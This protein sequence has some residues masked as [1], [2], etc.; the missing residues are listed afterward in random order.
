MAKFLHRLVLEPRGIVVRF[1]LNKQEI[2]E[3]TVAADL[4]IL[5]YLREKRGLVGTKEGC[6]S[7]DCGACTVLLGD[8]HGDQVVYHSVN[9]CITP[10]GSVAGK[11][12]VTVEHLCQGNLHPIQQAMVEYH[13]SQCGF[14]TPGF[15]M[16]LAGLYQNKAGSVD[17]AEVKECISGNLCRCTGYRP[18]VDAGVAMLAQV[19]NDHDKRGRQTLA[20]PD[21]LKLMRN[22]PQSAQDANQSV[23]YWKPRSMETLNGLIGKHPGAKLI[24]GGTDLGL[25]ITQRYQSLSTLIDVSDVSELNIL[26]CD[27]ETLTI[28]AAVTYATLQTNLAHTFPA[29]CQLLKRLGSQQIRNRGTIGGN[30]ANASPIADIPPVLLSMNATLE[31]ASINGQHRRIKPDDFYLAYKKTVLKENEYLTA[32]RIPLASLKH[33]HRFYKVSKRIE[34]DISSVMAAVRFVIDGGII[35]EAYLAFGG[36]AATPIRVRDVENQ[37]SGIA[38]NQESALCTALQ[39]LRQTLRPLSD[40]R[41]SADYRRQIA[42]NLVEKAWREARGESIPDLSRTGSVAYA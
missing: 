22:N 5:R 38:L 33:F 19:K 12:L 18:I 10:L 40:V 27:S 25:E 41:A 31:I 30:L 28:G 36:L 26:T 14:C 6:A 39:L 11:H 8:L 32:V 17:R 23:S 24:A 7:G 35:H 2:N 15:V 13:A 20:G 4:T 21:I 3:T 34:D 9:S 42:C 1:I 37:L 16:S 29:L